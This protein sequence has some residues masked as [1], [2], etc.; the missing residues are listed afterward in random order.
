MASIKTGHLAYSDVTTAYRYT[1]HDKK[2]STS[3]HIN[4]T[5]RNG[6]SRQ[7]DKFHLAVSHRLN[8]KFCVPPLIKA[9][10]LEAHLAGTVLLWLGEQG[11]VQV[12]EFVTP[13]GVADV[14][15]IRP[16]VSRVNERI[17]AGQLEPVTDVHAMEL[18]L[19]L[20]TGDKPKRTSD[21]ARKF[22]PL[23]GPVLFERAVRNLVRKRF[24]IQDGTS[25]VRRTDWMPYHD[26]LVA[27]ELKLRRIDEALAQ[28]RRHKA[29]T[30]ESYVG[31]PAVIAERVAFT[32]RRSEFEAAG[33]GLLSLQ[34]G[35]CKVLISPDHSTK[36]VIEAQQFSAAEACWRTVL[37]TIQH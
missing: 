24:L 1:N 33:V 16:N 21:V 10:D 30:A 9:A 29:I 35:S 4:Q 28:A 34:D 18:L 5:Q 17:S 26:Q 31:M 37:K 6:P 32:D 20:P 11:L 19:S 13:W 3:R 22:V 36:T 27:V 14:L 2:A 7:R 12:T 8:G 25:L 23:L 15:A